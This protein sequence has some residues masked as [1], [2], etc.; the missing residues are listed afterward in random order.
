[1]YVHIYIARMKLYI[2]GSMRVCVILFYILLAALYIYGLME[3][4]C[5]SLTF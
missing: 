5:I 2:Y 4:N 3:F 1:M